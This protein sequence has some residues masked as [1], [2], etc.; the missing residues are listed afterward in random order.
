MH[1]EEPDDEEV[2][3]QIFS[4]AVGD[5]LS[6]QMPLRVEEVLDIEGC[7]CLPRR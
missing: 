2:L 7:G 6:N 5:H 4:E 3:N 1:Y